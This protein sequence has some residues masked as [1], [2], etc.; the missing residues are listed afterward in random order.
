MVARLDAAAGDADLD[1]V[2]LEIAAAAGV[3][4]TLVGVQLV[5]PSPPGPRGV[6]RGGSSE[7]G[8]T[9]CLGDLE[10]IR[11]TLSL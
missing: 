10:N 7:Y 9:E 8:I 2:L 1:P 6:G 3:V 11:L 4:V 5:R